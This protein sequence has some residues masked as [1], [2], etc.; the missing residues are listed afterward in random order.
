MTAT[1]PLS[2]ELIPEKHTGAMQLRE[3][4]STCSDH[5]NSADLPPCRP[6]PHPPQDPLTTGRKR[7]HKR[8]GSPLQAEVEALSYPAEPP[9]PGHAPALDTAGQPL[10]TSSISAGG[11]SGPQDPPEVTRTWET[12]FRR[13]ISDKTC[14]DPLLFS[15]SS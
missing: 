10:E 5:T 3:R 8:W 12:L 2:N 6:L 14:V 15:L 11:S 4:E 13:P 7:C 9:R 1:H